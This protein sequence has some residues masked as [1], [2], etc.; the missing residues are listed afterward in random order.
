VGYYSNPKRC[1]TK[2]GKFHI[3][4]V[5]CWVTNHVN[6]PNPGERPHKTPGSVGAARSRSRESQGSGHE[7]ALGWL[8]IIGHRG[9][10]SGKR[11]KTVVND[12]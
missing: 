4:S 8:M 2:W 10:P 5:F 12:G 7:A 6:I 9:L 1:K 3:F 11:T